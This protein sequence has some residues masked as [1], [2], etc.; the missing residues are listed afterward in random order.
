MNLYIL[1]RFARKQYQAKRQFIIQLQSSIR[2]RVARKQLVGLRSEARSAHHLKE[3]SYKLENKIVELTQTL[4]ALKGDKKSANDR[5]T[6]LEA[7]IRTWAEK[8]EK[9][10]KKNKGLEARLQEP[11]V[12]QEQWDALQAEKDQLST[13]YKSSLDKIKNNEKQITQLIAQLETQKQDNERLQKALEEAQEKAKNAADEGEVAE[14]K[15]QIAALKAQLTQVLHTPRRQQSSQNNASS[16]RSLSPIPP[17]S[18]RSVSPAPISNDKPLDTQAL[19]DSLTA[20]TPRQLQQQKEKEQQEQ[21]EEQ[22]ST[23]T[24][25]AT[26][27]SGS[28]RSPSIAS[29]ASRKARRNSTADVPNNRSKTSIDNIRHAELLT[30]NPRPTSIHQFGS[31]L[32]GKAGGITEA[33]GENPEEEVKKKVIIITFPLFVVHKKF[34]S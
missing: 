30:R 17:A 29:P 34:Y 6:A 12:P 9:L 2:R 21:R 22:I 11:T 18:M 5:S 10:E 27:S 14:L 32:G 23:A 24:A 7:Q 3:V 33:I 31:P 28:S 26:G 8:Y 16:G 20:P 13:D 25:A 4:T 15:S 1:Y 19:K